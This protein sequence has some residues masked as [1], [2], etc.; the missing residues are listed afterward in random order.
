VASPEERTA[1]I[2]IVIPVY[3][4]ETSLPKVLDEIEHLA[5]PLEV[6]GHQL[7]LTEVVL[8]HDG[9]IDDS[10]RV[11]ADLA[12][13]HAFVQPIWMSRNFG[14]HPAT[15]AGIAATTAD[16]VV[17]MDEDGLHDPRSIAELATRALQDGADLVYGTPA[18]GIPH[19]WYRNASSAVAKWFFKL[20]VGKETTSTFTSF[21]LVDGTVARSLAAYYGEGVYLDVALTWVVGRTS[22]EPVTFRS[23]MRGEGA[24]SGYDVRKLLSHFRRLVVTSGTR[25]LRAI[26]ALGV[27]TTLAGLIMAIVVLSLRVFGD[28]AA[29]GW[30]SVM[31]AIAI[32]SGLVM[33]SLGVIAEYLS[34]AV[35]MAS[36]RP[37]Y[38]TLHRP[39][40]SRDHHDDPA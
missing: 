6:E 34:L 3:Q 5:W 36:G 4:G 17:T 1:S 27:L 37:P 8:V 12:Q 13:R 24:A 26:A 28:V 23:E 14:Q 25:P 16:W 10:A 38:L 21:R 31:I 32:F 19:H 30:A 18:E 9:A 11:I 20:L 7:E 35:S 22:Y 29:E 33:V 2:A 39:P 40:R 15:V